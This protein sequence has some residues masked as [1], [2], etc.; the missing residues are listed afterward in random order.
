MKDDNV[1]YVDR[2]AYKNAND[3]LGEIF[4]K[5]SGYNYYNNRLPD[6]VKMTAREYYLIREYK[7]DL[8]KKVDNDYYI[9][10]MKVVL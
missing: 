7:E 8:F 1:I 5:F 4:R 6:K 10:G 9:L 3:L 2:Y